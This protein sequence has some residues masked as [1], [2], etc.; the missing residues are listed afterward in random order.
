MEIRPLDGVGEL[1]PKLHG[2]V[3]RLPSVVPSG[4]TPAVRVLGKVIR[5][6][7]GIVTTLEVVASDSR[8]T[9][10]VAVDP[11]QVSR[12]VEEVLMGNAVVLKDDA[13]RLV[14]EEPRY[15]GAHGLPTAEVAVTE[16]RLHTTG[17]IN[18]RDD[19]SHLV[20]SS[21]VFWDIDSWA[22]RG[23]VQPAG[24]G[25]PNPLEGPSSDVWTVEYQE[26]DRRYIERRGPRIFATAHVSSF[27][28][29]PRLPPPVG[30]KSC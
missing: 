29:A 5:R 12:V 8:D 26:K 20:T 4:P 28:S 23:Y 1:W 15:A 6:I 3:E 14:V 2:V 16:Q 13:L 9:P 11:E 17:P 10:V 22:I 27:G 21:F 7:R 24:A 30:R 19:L 25:I 18:L